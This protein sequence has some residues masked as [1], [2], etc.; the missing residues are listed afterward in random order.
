MNSNR[1]KNKNIDGSIIETSNYKREK[2]GM[3]REDTLAPFETRLEKHLDLL[4]Q[5]R[6]RKWEK[7]VYDLIAP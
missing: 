4:S 1:I 2:K 5:V 3:I 6:Y 7:E